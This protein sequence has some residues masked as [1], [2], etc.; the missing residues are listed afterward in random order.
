IEV[1]DPDRKGALIEPHHNTYDIEFWGPDGMCTSFYLGALQAAVLIGKALEDDVSGYERLLQKGVAFM[2]TDLWNGEYYIQ[3]IEWRNLR[4]PNPTET[5]ALRT[6]YTPEALTLLEKE[7]PKYQYGDGCLS[8]GILGAWMARVCG[9]GVFLNTD[10][11]TSHLLAI[12]RH[13]LKRD[14]NAHANPQRPTYAIGNEGGLL[15][16]SWPTGGKLSLPFVYSDEVWTGIEYQV[17][18]HL[19]LMGRVEEGLEIVRICRDR[20]DGEIRNPFN[21]Y[22]CGHWYARA[23]ASYGLIQGLAGIRYDAVERTLHIAPSI[24]GDFR[25]FLATATGY[26]ISG[27]ENG[28]PFVEVREGRIDYARID[29]TPK[30]EV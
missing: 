13:N 16:C 21:E 8:D 14:L 22:E 30:R 6:N 25:S 29:Y 23:M 18:S 20:Y 26:G 17:A 24:L 12:H 27:V 7:G 2:E 4:A 10:K 9:A 19:M 11:E 1:W 3:K 28:Q 5:P 15:L